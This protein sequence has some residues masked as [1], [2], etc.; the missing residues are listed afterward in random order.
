MGKEIINEKIR[1]LVYRIVLPI[2][3]WS[4]GMKSLNEY[5]DAIVKDEAKFKGEK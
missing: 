1:H 2:Y 3:L 4:I 5:I